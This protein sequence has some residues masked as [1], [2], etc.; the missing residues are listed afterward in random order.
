MGNVHTGSS[1]GKVGASVASLSHWKHLRA[2]E[3][4]QGI[5]SVHLSRSSR[6]VSHTRS[7]SIMQSS[8]HYET[9]WRERGL[10]TRIHYTRVTRCT[11]R[12]NRAPEG[13]VGKQKWK[14]KFSNVCSS[15]FTSG[16]LVQLRQCHQRSSLCFPS[17]SVGEQTDRQHNLTGIWLSERK[18]E[19][20]WKKADLFIKHP[21][22]RVLSLSFDQLV[23]MF[24]I[25]E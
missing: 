8:V 21:F 22:Q 14:N 23:S 1:R 15:S 18:D 16:T 7:Q 20:T 13:L 24:V 17:W 5:T 2:D 6:T 12:M 3:C 19:Q 9:C 10:I 25:T 4:S 11:G